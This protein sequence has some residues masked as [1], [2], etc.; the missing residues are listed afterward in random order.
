M[1]REAHAS[2]AR[3]IFAAIVQPAAVTTEPD[4]AEAVCLDEWLWD[5]AFDLV[6]VARADLLRRPLC[7][8]SFG[9]NG[10]DLTWTSTDRT[11]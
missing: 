1:I 2:F 7:A 8:E 9:E 6:Q 3:P 4:V 5:H 10:G 11:S